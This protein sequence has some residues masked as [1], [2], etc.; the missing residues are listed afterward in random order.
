MSR[1]ASGTEGSTATIPQAHHQAAAHPDPSADHKVSQGDPSAVC[2]SISRWLLTIAMGFEAAVVALLLVLSLIF[3]CV[4]KHGNGV[5]PTNITERAD[6]HFRVP[7][8]AFIGGCILLFMALMCIIHGVAQIKQRRLLLLLLTFVTITQILWIAALELTSYGYPDS[9]SLIDGAD[10]LINGDIARYYPTFCQP[11]TQSEL[12][13]ARPHAVPSPHAYFSYYP[14]QTG[15][16]LWYVFAGSIFGSHNIIA[17]Q[18]L[19]AFAIT[20][21][22][23]ALW[24]LG[25]LIGLDDAGH[26]ALATLLATC[27]PLL[28]FATFVYPNAVG[29]SITVAGVVLIAQAFRVQHAWQCV[30]A[31]VS[32]FLVCGIGVILKSTFI[33]LMLA[34]IIGIVLVVAANRKWWQGAVAIV[35]FGAAYMI[36]K[37]PLCIIEHITHQNFGKGMPML[38]WITLGLNEREPTMPGW[39]TGIPLHTFHETHGDYA[40]QSQVAKDFVMERM[41]YFAHNPGDGTRFFSEKLASEWAEP[42]FMTSLYS[43]YG[44]S[45]HGF[46]GLPQWLLSGTGAARLTSYENIAQ[47]VLYA[48]AL[49]GVVAM[50]TSVVRSAKHPMEDSTIFARTFLCAAFLG[51]FLCYL[52]WEAKGIY[53]LPFYL[54]LFPLAAYG[55]QIIKRDSRFMRHTHSRSSSVLLDDA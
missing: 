36:T 33:I 14:F 11:R 48:L 42:T 9:Q 5:G 26:A 10:A 3:T 21:L 15:P 7:S 38:S 23:A 28:M 29:F 51:G 45:A 30:L 34:A 22:V 16:M 55:V 52:F 20:G 2:A 18:I 4:F 47:T 19:N 32:G 50:L 31:L 39:W 13:M 46:S 25:T 1:T 12:C 53:T 37:L 49:A 41:Q 43:Q 44:S 6:Y 35:S 17:F 40:R 8:F 27:V 24:R 54:L